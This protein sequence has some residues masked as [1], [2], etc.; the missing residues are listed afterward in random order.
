MRRTWLVACGAAA[1]AAVVGCGPMQ[2]PMPVRLD[3]RDQK[4][5][6]ESWEKALAP[7]DRY[8]HQAWLDIMLVT[9]AYQLGVD[10]L[11]FHSEKRFSG[12]TVVMEINYDRARPDSDR[13]EVRVLDKQGKVLRSESY[14][15]ADV[16]NTYKELFNECDTLRWKKENGLAKPEDLR[17][18][19][20][21]EGRRAKVADV[22]PDSP[23]EKGKGQDTGKRADGTSS[24][25]GG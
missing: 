7:V 23:K 11:N 24:K 6:D 5:I 3:D 8:D 1:L 17:K 18:L 19:E 22:F 12:G 15:R 14:G 2:S 20:T 10:R 13:F 16:E 25:R 9:Q 21:L 4:K